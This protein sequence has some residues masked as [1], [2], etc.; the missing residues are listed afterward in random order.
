MKIKDS[1]YCLSINKSNSVK[2]EYFKMQMQF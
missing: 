2:K 1:K